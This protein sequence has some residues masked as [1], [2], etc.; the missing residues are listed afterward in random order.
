[1][2][3]RTR[4]PGWAMNSQQPTQQNQQAVSPEQ[5]FREYDNY[6]RQYQGDPKTEFEEK[7]RQ[8]GLNPQQQQMVLQVAERFQKMA[9]MFKR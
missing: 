2:N 5:A 7:C 4:A 6:C 8:M 3:A 9:G 1:M